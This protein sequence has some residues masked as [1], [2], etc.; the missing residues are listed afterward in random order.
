MRPIRRAGMAMLALVA[1]ATA[2]C[3]SSTNPTAAPTSA[4]SATSQTGTSSPQTTA[5]ATTPPPPT[6]APEGLAWP[7]RPRTTNGTGGMLVAIRAARHQDFD[8]V[9]F[10]FAEGLPPASVRYVPYLVEDPRGGLLPL[11]GRAFLQ[12]V[13]KHASTVD[14]RSSPARRTYTGPTVI[15]PGLP[16]LAQVR[17]AGD[18]EAVLSF[19]LGLNQRAGFRVLTLSGPWR[20]VVDVSHRPASAVF[21]GIWPFTSQQ[22]AQTAQQAVNEGHQPWLLDPRQVASAFA[23]EVLGWVRPVSR[24][25][26]PGTVT[27]TWSGSEDVVRAELAQPVRQGSAGIWMITRVV[28]VV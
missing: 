9:V 26:G 25:T 7:T 10:E 3:Q 6:S 24:Q 27:V 23:S 1:L 28:R 5:P 4:T 8:R 12:V 16:S 18:F 17:L 22:Q 19:G 13:F 2:G 21:A 11:R 14:Q 20:V 15:T